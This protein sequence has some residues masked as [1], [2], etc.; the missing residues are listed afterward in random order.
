MKKYAMN[1]LTIMQFIFLIHGA[2]VGMGVMSLPRELAEIAGTDGWMSL[3]I[4]WALNIAASLIIIRIFKH[5]PDDT[6][7]DLLR[8]LFGKIFSLVFLIPITLYF[9]YYGWF[10]Q[11]KALLYIKAWFLPMT[12][13]YIIM[14]LFAISTLLVVR[15][16]WTV[17]GR[18]SELVFYLTFAMPFIFLL[19]LKES[20]WLHLLP[21]FK[22]GVMPV[23]KSVNKTAYSLVG[24]EITFFLYPFLNKKKWAP[25]GVIAANSLTAMLYI[26][27]T[28]IC[29][30]FF[31]PDEITH[32]NQPLLS[33]L[34]VFEF[35][36]LERFDLIFL[37]FYLL[38]VS[39]SW[40]PYLFCAAFS[41]SQM[42]GK[43]DHSPYAIVL[44]VISVLAVAFLKPSWDETSIWQTWLGQFS[45]GIAYL[46]PVLLWL[47][48]IIYRRFR[49]EVLP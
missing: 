6:L 36:F 49:K 23:L 1:N 27:V 44:L 33:L 30:V 13:D 42:L 28:V 2:Q 40:A 37:A 8:R 20:Y 38:V 18:Y 15:S 47:Y 31:S 9:A 22:E 29:F 16:G 25:L 34:K 4:G 11:V 10:I 3:L 21:F 43:Q 24:F 17:L 26:Y 5:Y 41:T 35:R 7:Y 48:V 46:F 32:Y 14:A 45:I 19:V 12:S 39:T